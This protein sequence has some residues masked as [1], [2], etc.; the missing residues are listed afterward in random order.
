M[1]N[2][3]TSTQFGLQS[4]DELA[5]SDAPVSR[6]ERKWI[7]WSGE[8]ESLRLTTQILSLNSSPE[9]FNKVCILQFV[10]VWLMLHTVN[11]LE[12]M[13]FCWQSKSPASY[14][15]LRLTKGF[16]LAQLLTDFERSITLSLSIDAKNCSDYSHWKLNRESTHG[17]YT[18]PVYLS[19]N[20]SINLC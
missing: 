9:A 6:K 13:Y 19:A 11:S 17:F 8:Q 14:P 4:E 2:S 5:R 16:P 18:Q 10:C 1:Q 3:F 15:G 12:A 7:L 20:Q